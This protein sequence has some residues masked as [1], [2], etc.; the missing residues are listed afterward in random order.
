MFGASTPR[1]TLR[2]FPLY[3]A[4]LGLYLLLV[5]GTRSGTPQGAAFMHHLPAFA[6]YTTNWF[7]PTG[8]GNSTIF[9]FVWSLAT[10]EQFYL[11]W[12]LA[13]LL[14]LGPGRWWRAGVVMLALIAVSEIAQIAIDGHG[15]GVTVL[16]SIAA[17]ICLGAIWAL[18]LHSPR[19]F[20]AAQRVLGHRAAAPGLLAGLVVSIAIFAPLGI[21]EFLL[22]ALV[23]A[24][25]IREDN[26]AAP[27]LTARPMRFLGEISYGRYLLHML[28]IDSV[29]PVVG[30]RFG[31]AVFIVGTGVTTALA[32]ASFRWFEAPKLRYRDRF[33]RSEPQAAPTVRLAGTVPAVPV[34]FRA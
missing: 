22:A 15:F 33:R 25:C 29:R 21:L 32:Y 34:R 16:R 27:L 17:P 6:T 24:C 20:A 13:L 19:G 11:L 2:I 14:C 1:R 5:L 31:V 7:V 10:Q 8:N 26:L 23:A 9:Y 30:A 3:F 18:T 4:V 28:A 12:P